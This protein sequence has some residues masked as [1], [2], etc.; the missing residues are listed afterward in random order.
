MISSSLLSACIDKILGNN[1]YPEQHI[2]FLN[3]I[4]NFSKSIEAKYTS[5]FPYKLFWK[6]TANCNLRCKHCY[7]VG[8]DKKFNKNSDLSTSRIL[9]LVDEIDEMNVVNLILTG[10]EL[11]TRH[12]IFKIIQKIK[13]KNIPVSLSTNATLITKDSAKKLKDVLNPLVD[14]IQISLDG[15]NAKTH[16]FIRG[17]GNFEKTIQGIKLLTEMKLP[18]SLN[19][20]I[21]K[22]NIDELSDIYLLADA[23]GVKKISFTKLAQIK[24]THNQY[25]VDMEYVMEQLYKVIE[26][27]KNFH[28]SYLEILGIEV[29]DLLNIEGA[30]KFVD[31]YLEKIPKAEIYNCACQSDNKAYIDSNGDVYL[32][33]MTANNPKY[34]LG[35]IKN[36]SFKEV[37]EDRYLNDF[38][39]KK[40]SCD[41]PCK[42]CK[43]IRLCKGGCSYYAKETYGTILAP[44]SSCQ[45]GKSLIKSL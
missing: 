32:C 38:F 11:F 35:N 5:A 23:L 12:D 34:I 27:E 44:N 40:L 37:W 15:A 21:T 8:D 16:D 28:K 39:G 24:N 4:M 14:N 17:N 42:K 29:C 19:A 43:Y 20:V 10:G 31:K 9:D 25:A 6:V 30:D 41:M 3:G 7:F 45:R 1:F 2:K 36:K 26:L 18:I 33:Q 22:N 13:S